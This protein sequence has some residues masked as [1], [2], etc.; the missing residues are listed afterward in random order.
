MEKKI[1]TKKFFNDTWFYITFSIYLFGVL[2]CG[3]CSYYA[4]LDF[5]EH[6]IKAA[7]PLLIIIATTIIVIPIVAKLLSPK[8]EVSDIIIQ[9]ATV[10]EKGQHEL[11]EL[12]KA[13]PKSSI[14]ANKY[15]RFDKELLYQQHESYPQIE[16][17]FCFYLY[18][19]LWESINIGDR[20][21]IVHVR[22][23]NLKHTNVYP[24]S[25]WEL[26]EELK[27]LVK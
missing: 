8:L 21:Y 5:Q 2:L 25:Q 3:I 6:G 20:C 22:A 14:I 18:K 19:E 24:C 11:T 16:T 23:N 1:L 17:N 12:Q 7:M 15:L 4:V 13:L 10:T 27:T 26:A 9:V